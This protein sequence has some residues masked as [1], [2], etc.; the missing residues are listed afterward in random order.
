MET[1]VYVYMSVSF[2]FKLTGLLDI[3]E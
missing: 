2:I 1:T 3:T